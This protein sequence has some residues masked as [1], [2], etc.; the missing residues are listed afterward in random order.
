MK[1]F[2]LRVMVFFVV[3]L[4]VFSSMGNSAFA[5]KEK[6]LKW[7]LTTHSLVGT[8]R[9]E[10]V[11]KPFCEMV[12][13]LSNGRFIIEPYGAGVLFPVFESFGATQN[14]MVDAMMVYSGYWAG[15]DPFFGV[16]PLGPASPIMTYPEGMYLDSRLFPLFE[17]AYAKHNL[18]YLGTADANTPEFLCSNK[19]IRSMA[20]FKG[21]KIRTSAF[22]AQM[23]PLFGA[24]AVSLSGPEIYT[25]L[26]TGT[27][28]AA[29]Y[30]DYEENMNMGLH[31]V[32]KYAIEPFLH[33][34]IGED[35]PLVINK[36]SWDSL[37]EEF[38]N[39]IYAALDHARY[40][41]SQSGFIDTIIARKKW[42][43]AGV[44]TI[45]IPEDEV[46]AIRA[47]ALEFFVDWSKDKPSCQ[48]YIEVYSK[49][50]Y[51]LGYEV[52][53]KALGYTP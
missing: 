16:A 38:K 48:E 47:A 42:A 36:K 44:E 8:S 19:P 13:K 18:V 9:F 40:K 27:I 24:S 45:V 32:S 4:M 6:T 50:L 49:T 7:R 30:T 35:K 51:E 12:N 29:E 37:S 34:G 1:R 25:A 5:A 11:V 52:E 33:G 3:S 46:T 39:I 43:E 31:E 2:F 21:V 10:N 17:K 28:D 23:Y 20:D 14:G 53:A 22:G 41:S 15:K 26:Q